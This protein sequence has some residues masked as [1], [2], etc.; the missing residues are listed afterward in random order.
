MPM[1]CD[2]MVQ[3]GKSKWKR[4]GILLCITGLSIGISMGI[5]ALLLSR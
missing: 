1:M 3:R 4:V 2:A 5:A